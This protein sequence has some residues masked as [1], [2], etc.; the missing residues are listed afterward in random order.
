MFIGFLEICH[1]QIYEQTKI[2]T[3]ASNHEIQAPIV[4]DN[5]KYA[6]SQYIYIYIYYILLLSLYTGHY[7]VYITDKASRYIHK[8]DFLVHELHFQMCV[9]V[10]LK[11]NIHVH[12]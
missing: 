4:G 6:F 5:K 2:Q 11:H 1:S 12:L 10:K 7:I 8:Q 9:L 3:D